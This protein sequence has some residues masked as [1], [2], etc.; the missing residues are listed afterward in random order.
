M[1]ATEEARPGGALTGCRVLE[2][3]HL[4]GAVAGKI[5][6]DLGAE[7]IKIE[8]RGGEHARR[9]EPTCVDDRGE[10]HGLEFLAFNTSKRTVTIDLATEAGLEVFG[11]LAEKADIVV[12]DWE[13]IGDPQESDRLRDRCRRD[14]PGLVWCE[15]WPYGRGEFDTTLATEFTLQAQ[16]GHLYLNG[17]IERPPV[18]ICAPVASAQSGAE[19]AGAALM[20]YY[21]SLRT[22]QGQRVDI[23]VQACVVWTLLNTTMTWQCLGIDEV[24]GGSVKR[25]RGNTFF[26][27]LVWPCQDGFIQFGPVGG[28]GGAVREASFAKLVEWMR[29]EGYYQPILD[30]HDWNGEARFTV[31]QQAYD[32]VTE[33]IGGFIKTRTLD[34]LIERGMKNGMLLAPVYS[35]AQLLESE[36]LAAREFF[37]E[38]TDEARGLTARLPGAFAR[39]EGTPLL[40]P[41]RA[42]FA[43]EDTIDVLSEIGLG[44]D[45]I[46]NLLAA[47]AL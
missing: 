18:R 32:E 9:S 25:E 41:H 3:S 29:E 8:P 10:R 21:H 33:V 36:Q 27:R 30:A 5:L 1:R 15:I 13:R 23:S 42:P 6:A 11:R 45:D 19:A 37:V 43:G 34:E 24:R 17:E 47:E 28:G 39:M 22:G 40:T 16:G 46:E 31:P 20:A 4:A 14:N 38:L 35:I 12:L 2:L 26:T 7:V 44:T